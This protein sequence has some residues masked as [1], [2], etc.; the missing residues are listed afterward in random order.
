[1]AREKAKV[2]GKRV[3]SIKIKD[4]ASRWGSCSTD[5]EICFSWRLAFAIPEAIDYVVAHE[6]AHLKA[7][8]S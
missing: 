5:A 3:K 1:M 4:T 2:L 6:V 7:H 8:G